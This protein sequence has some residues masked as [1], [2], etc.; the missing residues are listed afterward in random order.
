VPVAA[1]EKSAVAQVRAAKPAVA[2]AAKDS[3]GYAVQVA[4]LNIRGE[5]DAIAKRLASKGYAAYVMAP[6]N[7]TP[8]VFRVRVGKF[9]TRREA[10]TVAAKLQKEEQFKPWITR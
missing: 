6:A 5:A 7:G 10:E 2:T 8:A 1:A 3:S 9:G 4:A